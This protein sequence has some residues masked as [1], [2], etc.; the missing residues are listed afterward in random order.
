MPGNYTMKQEFIT[1]NGKV[2]RERDI[3]FVKTLKLHFSESLLGQWLWALVPVLAI[4]SST[5]LQ[6]GPARLT[7]LFY[8]FL[9]FDNLKLLYR[10]VFVKSFAGRIPLQNIIS[11]ETKNDHTGLETEVIL[12]LKS[13]RYRTV[14]FRTLENQYQSFTELISQQIS[15]PQ[16]A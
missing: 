13:G 5:L 14:K 3:L 9:F 12:K 10:L 7:G 6:E 1:S 11:F 16:L 4:A 8:L 15:Q 2:V